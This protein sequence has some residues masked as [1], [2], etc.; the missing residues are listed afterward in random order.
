M[1]E[2]ERKFLLRYLPENLKKAQSIKQSYLLMDGKSH[3]RVRIIDNQIGFLT[4]KSALSNTIKNE[5]EYEIPLKD[6]AE[7]FNLSLYKLEK[8][9]YKTT[10]QGNTVDIDIYPNGIQIVE[11]EFED[12][13]TEL[14]DYC[15]D[16]VSD[17]PR[18]SN[19]EIAKKN[20]LVN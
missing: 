10:F 19:I 18:F 20:G 13:L 4:Y 11:I 16:D 12:E 5:F 7:L 6:A 17:D 8:Q 1:K 2:Q 3:L 14:P 15:G 9:R